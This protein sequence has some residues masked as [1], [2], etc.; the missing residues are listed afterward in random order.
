MKTLIWIT[1]DMRRLVLMTAL[2]VVVFTVYILAVRNE[3]RG[4]NKGKDDV[5]RAK[6]FIVVDDQGRDV[7]EFGIE[8]ESIRLRIPGEK[9]GPGVFVG[10]QKNGTHGI[11]L[12]DGE[13]QPLAEFSMRSEKSTPTV[14]LGTGDVPV[15]ERPRVILYADKNGAPGLV[16]FDKNG[17]LISQTP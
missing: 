3:A 14:W 6:K 8:G 12:F 2:P 1:S 15:S 11:I 5:V 16:F 4:Q 17:K 13:N 7:G 10:V 9:G